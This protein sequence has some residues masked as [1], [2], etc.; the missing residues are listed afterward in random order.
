[1]PRLT[2]VDAIVKGLRE[3]FQHDE[4][5][6]LIGQDIG[7]MGGAMQSYKGLW[8]EFGET[9]R[10][11]DMPISEEGVAAACFGAAMRGRRPVF[12]IT[13][14]E[15]TPLTMAL[16]GS[17][18]GIFFKTDGALTAPLVMR[19][20]FG[21]G[22]HRGHAEDFHSM[23]AHCPGVKVVMPASPYDGKGLIKA[24]IRDPNPVVFCEHMALMH[25]LREEVPDDDYIVPLGAAAIKREGRDVT[26]VAS[27]LMVSRSLKA[28]E[29]L[30]ERGIEA[31]VVDLRTISPPDYDMIL[32]SLE[33]TG[34]LV[35]V[36]EAWRECG[37]GGELAAEV[38]ERGF[39]LLKG[40]IKRVASPNLPV[41]F[42]LPLEKS[43]IPDEGK[44]A[45]AARE[46]LR[47]GKHGN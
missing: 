35:V 36:H 47:F 27:G 10:I 21:A 37:S 41:P 6:F 1:M 23:F 29:K 26:I 34:H 18:A 20:K 2:L 40:P 25:G 16:F 44:I 3:E 38:A 13:F 12:E 17:E 45:A 32:Q 42:S 7:Q 5:I 15:C 9:G 39:G 4:R 11:I 28:A 31:E 30:S 43:F 46:T 14:S 8:E 22:P 24:A 19:T 33:K